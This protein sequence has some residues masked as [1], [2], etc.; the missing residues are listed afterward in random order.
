LISN[1]YLS[2]IGRDYSQGLGIAAGYP[3]SATIEHNELTE[4]PYM[5]IGVG[6]GWADADNAA[7]NNSIRNNKIWNVLKL[8]ADGGAIYTLSRQPGTVIAENYVHDIARTRV[9][10]GY[11]INGIFLDQGSNLITVRNNVLVKTGDRRIHMNDTGPG[12][13][14]IDN[15]GTS[16]AVIANAGLEP[17]Y[18]NIRPNSAVEP[19]TAFALNLLWRFLILAALAL[20]AT[21][22]Y[23]AWRFSG[24]SN[25][26]RR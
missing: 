23:Y 7:R 18:R 11:F 1:N 26:H 20:A 19:A 8:I 4:M 24:R 10:G 12:N 9:H 2:G 3:D 17:E 5:G 13:S 22:I 16:A 6:W 15:D 14:F 25:I 21:L